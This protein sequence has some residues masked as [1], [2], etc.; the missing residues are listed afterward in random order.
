MVITSRRSFIAGLVSFVAAP[1]IVRAA[2]IMPV[3]SVDDL[4]L[5]QFGNDLEVY[6][7]SPAMEVLPDLMTIQRITMEMIFRQP[8]YNGVPVFQTDTLL[9]QD[10]WQ[11]FPGR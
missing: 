3:K 8:R 7:H 1:A 4:A 2:N 10:G 6:G 9:P 11:G 5:W